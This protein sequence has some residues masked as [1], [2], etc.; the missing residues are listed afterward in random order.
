MRAA[1]AGLLL[2]SCAPAPGP[3]L[4]RFEVVHTD[5]VGGPA[6][7]VRS[8]LP[9]QLAVITS[10]T[11]GSAE[12][13]GM[14]PLRHACDDIRA[15]LVADTAGLT[16]AVEVREPR[17]HTVG[18]ERQDR[19]TLAHYEATIRDLAEGPTRVRVRHGYPPGSGGAPDPPP[20]TSR[21]VADDTVGASVDGRN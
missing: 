7:Q 16:L 14:L 6:E 1:L 17:R 15:R 10:G 4:E 9:A 12:I 3:A 2:A 13:R 19:L 20:W 18:C 21:V 5:A 11:P 8:N